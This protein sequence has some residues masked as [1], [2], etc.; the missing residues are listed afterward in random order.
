MK[1]IQDAAY[2]PHGAF[3]NDSVDR[4]NLWAQIIRHSGNLDWQVGDTAIGRTYGRI[5]QKRKINTNAY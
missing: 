1:C 5:A 3:T 2:H 4:V